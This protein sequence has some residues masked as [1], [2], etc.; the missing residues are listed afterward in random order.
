MFE[1]KN[2]LYT[3]SQHTELPFPHILLITAS[4]GSGKTHTL[5]RRYVQFLL[6]ENIPNNHL[7]NIVAITFTNNAATE[8]KQRVLELLKKIS[9]HDEKLVEWRLAAP[10]DATGISKDGASAPQKK[11]AVLLQ[12]IFDNYSDFQIKTIDSFMTTIFKSSSLEFGYTPDFTVLLS[13][14]AL[15]D[16]AFEKFAREAMQNT[17]L[18]QLLDRIV[19]IIAENSTDKEK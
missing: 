3:T 15:L 7:R 13:A 5:T 17:Q 11:S 18:R 1:I 2:N 16:E 8:M 6:S 19:R 12:E 14:D 4:A 9:L 10:S